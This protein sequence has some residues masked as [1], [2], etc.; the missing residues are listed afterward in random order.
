MQVAYI[1]SETAVPPAHA[2]ADPNRKRMFQPG[3]YCTARRAKTIQQRA[4]F[5][6]GAK[7]R[8]FY[9]VYKKIP[10]LFINWP[11]KFY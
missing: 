8:V 10:D 3:I 5:K 6:T 9:D 2:F 4:I 11:G 1:P 7:V